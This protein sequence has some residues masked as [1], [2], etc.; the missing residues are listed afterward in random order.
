MRGL[1]Q[2]QAVPQ[3]KHILCANGDDEPRTEQKALQGRG[4][5]GRS[6]KGGADRTGLVMLRALPQSIAVGKPELH[7]W[8]RIAGHWQTR[9]QRQCKKAAPSRIATS[10]T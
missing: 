8:A 2:R 1:L 4:E 9:W 5:K 3:D 10:Q 6:E 7:C